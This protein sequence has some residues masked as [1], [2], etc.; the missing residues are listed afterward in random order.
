MIKRHTKPN[1]QQEHQGRH[2][3]AR[4]V[5]AR[6]ERA[7]GVPR[8]RQADARRPQDARRR[9]QGPHLPQV[10]GSGR[11]MSR[12]KERVREG[13]GAGAHEGVRLHERDGRAEDRRRSSSTWASAR[14]RRTPR[15]S[16]P[17]PTS[18]RA[19]PARSRSTRRAKKSIAQFKVRKGMPI[20]DDGDAARRA[21]VGVPRSAGDRSRCR[22]CATS[23]ACRRRAS[24]AAAT[25]RSAC[26][27]SCC[28]PRSTT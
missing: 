19:S 25:T 13:S 12:L 17:A 23:A 3:G 16:T 26:G 22:A 15:S 7:A 28:S 20:G 10:R 1:P 8:V 14:R 5:A 21:D 11:Q 6:V 4:G 9:P 18:S 24:T 2:R 27:T